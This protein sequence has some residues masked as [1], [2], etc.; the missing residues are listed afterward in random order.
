M[1]RLHA[2]VALAVLAAGCEKSGGGG[3]PSTDEGTG[4]VNAVETVQK[5][6][7]TVAEF[8]DVH[9]D[10]ASAPVIAW[11]ALAPG[12]TA[13]AKGTW[14][15]VNLWATWCH[16]C[17]EEM[18]LLARW[19]EALGAQGVKYDN[20]FLSVDESEELITRFRASH[21]QTPASLRIASADALPDWLT[22]LG[23]PGAPIPVHIFLDP[24]DRVRCVRAGAVK[25]SDQP[26][27]KSVL[28]GG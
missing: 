15:W 4:R 16:P 18:P 2:L 3:E 9:A 27:V 1:D 20:V 10:A 8:C 14:R 6:P 23:V 22:A 11:P 13:P 5:K 24:E 17:V 25:E 12:Q 21:P 26:A 28:G 19:R 7:V